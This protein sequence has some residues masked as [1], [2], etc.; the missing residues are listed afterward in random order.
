M[1]QNFS[2]HFLIALQSMGDPYFAG[3]LTLVCEH[4]E[5]GA[6]GLI[7]NKPID[8]TLKDLFSQVGL[9][10]TQPHLI[11]RPVMFGGPVQMDRGFVLH[12]PAGSW[13]SSLLITD[14]LAFTTSKDILAAVSEGRG[15]HKL[16][17]TLGYAGWDAGQLENE[18]AQGAW[19]TVPADPD[20]IFDVPSDDRL[21]AA[22]KLL[23]IDPWSLSDEVGHA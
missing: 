16:L 1:E 2:N 13:Q 14:D 20:I 10:L 21:A 4:N 8:L 12:Q 6:L 17:L 19:L 23:G 15:P 18:L 11:N 7:V 3:A 5:H 9:P 22:M